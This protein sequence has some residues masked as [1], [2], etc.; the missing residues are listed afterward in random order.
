MARVTLSRAPGGYAL[1]LRHPKLNARVHVLLRGQRHPLAQHWL[2]R[3]LA[4]HRQLSSIHVRGPRQ[5]I[6]PP[7]LLGVIQQVR[8]NPAMPERCGLNV[9]LVV[10]LSGS[11]G[12]QG[13]KTIKGVVNS[14]ASRLQGTDTNLGLF[15]FA[16]NSPAKRN[17]SNLS[18]PVSV[19]TQSGQAAIKKWVDGLAIPTERE[20]QAT[21]WQEALYRVAQYNE[22]NPSNQYD[23]VYMITDGNPTVRKD[24]AFGNTNA[25][26]GFLTPD[27]AAT[28]FR[29]IEG[30]IGA[31]NM[32]KAQGTRIVAVG[33]PSRWTGVITN[34]N[35][36]LAVSDENLKSISGGR[37][38]RGGERNLR[39]ADFA[40]FERSDVMQQARECQDVCVCEAPIE[41]EFH[42]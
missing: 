24:D 37:G 22:Q 38:Y 28:E 30:A 27:G 19:S 14:V 6:K 1:H 18:S 10:D 40:Q 42:R 2:R 33:I 15:N 9:A 34:R 32:V 23:V 36:Q 11:M 21:N 8:D 25:G 5:R 3:R 26:G 12:S 17:G 4:E 16:E 13:L 35:D 39:A 31:A 41:R 29:D 20:G 7:K